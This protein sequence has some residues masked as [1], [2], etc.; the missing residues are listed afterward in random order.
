MV[1]LNEDNGKAIG[2]LVAASGFEAEIEITMEA[3]VIKLKNHSKELVSK[4]KKE[5]TVAQKKKVLREI[6][7]KNAKKKRRWRT[8][9]KV[10]FNGESLTLK[11]WAKKLGITESGVSYRIKAHGNPYGPNSPK[12]TD[13]DKVVAAS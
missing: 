5:P 13:S 6:L 11:E 12:P 2:A 10:T 8:G 1:Y 4:I 3:I 7:T 9:G